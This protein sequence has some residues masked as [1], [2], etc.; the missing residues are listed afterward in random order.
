ML[1]ARS[2]IFVQRKEGEKL[3]A[4]VA[5]KALR[6]NLEDGARETHGSRGAYRGR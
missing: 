4:R 3:P 1:P 2:S 5:W 6:K